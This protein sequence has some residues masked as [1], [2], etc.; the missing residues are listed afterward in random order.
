MDNVEASLLKQQ[1][2]MLAEF[3]S[4]KTVRAVDFEP[5]D[6][7]RF[8]VPEYQGA[9][10]QII[11]LKDGESQE[12]RLIFAALYAANYITF[13]LDEGTE[14][15]R[16]T[17]SHIV[18]KFMI[19][20]NV[21]KID[22]F[23]RV[24]ILKC[25]ESYRVE[26]D[27]V[28]TQSTGMIE[29]IR[30]IN[31]ALNY[32]PFGNELLATND[33]RYLDLLSKSKPA[34]SDGS[35]QT[36]LTDYFGFHSWLRRDDIGVGAQLYKRAESPKLL[37]WSFQIT[38][39]S[40][41]IE[42][43]KAKHALIDLFNKKRVQPKYFPA[44]LIRPHLDNYKG[45]RE[46]KQFRVDEAAF[47]VATLT[48]KRDF[49]EKL[50]NVLTGIEADS[51]INTALES[52]IYSQCVEEAQQY[53]KDE[54]WNTGKIATQTTKISNK[55]VTVFRQVT[56]SS[57]LFTPDFIQEL[58]EY[59][60][61]KKRKIPISKGENYLFAL[62]MSYQT[63]PYN[64]L[65]KIKLSDFR[66]SK[67]QTGEV[68]QIESDYFKSR[69]KSYH[70]IEAVEG[71]SVLGTS[72]IAFLNDRTDSLKVNSKLIDN[73]GSLQ[74]KMGITTSISLFFKFLGKSHIRDVLNTQLLKEK[75]SP[76][77]IEC[78]VAICEKGIRKEAYE[79][80]NTNWLLN[81][82][83]PT[84]T[85]IFSSEAVKN[86]KVHSQSD[87]FDPTRITNY[88]SH[89][90]ETERTNYRTEDNQTWIDNCGKI[91]RTVMND[92]SLNVLRP[93][94]SEVSEYN[95][96]IK[97]ALQTLKLKADNTL[98]L[99][100]VVTG[101]SDGKVNDLGFLVSNKHSED[102]LPDNIYLVDSPETVLKFLHYLGEIER[103]HQKIFERAPE[104]LFLEALP[105]AE[106]IEAVLSNRLFSNETVAEGQKL[107]KKYK[108]DLPPIFTAF[109]GS[110]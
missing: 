106:W 14:G 56:E 70:E 72:I 69:A 53:A 36:T 46:S 26:N 65:F 92:I 5:F 32:V 73:D 66:F 71:N 54:F 95:T 103:C 64:D 91:T 38:I 80:K 50:R 88:N 109:T 104:Y 23:N 108:K 33:Y 3:S 89:T 37:M 82:E 107:Y 94:K 55:R 24:N 41:L 93:S 86:S 49:F 17:L 52:L 21:L 40:A 62:L 44:K 19:Y 74:S 43:N 101:K 75:V 90:N 42:I 16:K 31:K 28:K 77:F 57:L 13:V 76:V 27:G 20:L 25:F 30:L 63:V 102:S 85:R 22:Q 110:Y 11:I 97:S 2:E 87:N 39:S 99:L 98:A 29:L 79:R 47:K 96:T 48:N 81:C 51:I 105:T 8:I 18:P 9:K 59:S 68:T 67:R 1:A 4:K 15:Y 83:T 45:G 58:V 100:K 34:V 78:V 12:K 60:Q 10:S 7:D 61:A 35:V 84:V 6:V